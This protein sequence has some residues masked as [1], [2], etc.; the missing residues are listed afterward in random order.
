VPTFDETVPI[1]RHSG[2]RFEPTKR[3]T[4]DRT[5]GQGNRRGDAEA[6]SE[7]TNMSN[8]KVMRSRLPARRAS[9]TFTFEMEGLHYRATISRFPKDGYIAEIFLSNDKSG[10]QADANARDAAVAASLAFQYGCPLS[11]L[12]GAL[13]RDLRGKA[14][15]PLGVALDLV[16]E[17]ERSQANEE[18]A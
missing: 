5:Q 2:R 15:T 16:A 7:E 8:S 13:L 6:N 12:R 10:S 17:W 4:A 3:V 9:E 18:M 1:G 11:V 14:A